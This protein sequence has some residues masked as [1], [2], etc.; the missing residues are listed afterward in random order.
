MKYAKN[1]ADFW[2]TIKLCFQEINL[3][4]IMFAVYGYSSNSAGLLNP[5]YIPLMN[6]IGLAEIK[7]TNEVLEIYVKDYCVRNFSLSSNDFCIIPQFISYIKYATA[8]HVGFIRHILQYTMD[9]LQYKIHRKE[10]I[11]K[12]IYK[13]LNSHSFYQS[14]NNCH[15]T[16]KFNELSRKQQEICESVYLNRSILFLA[17]CDN[18]YLVK[19]RIFVVNVINNMEHLCFTVPLIE[20]FFFHQQYYGS[21][22]SASSTS[23]SL[24]EFIV[25]TFTIICKEKSEILKYSLGYENNKMLLEQILQKEFYRIG[26]R[27]LG[28]QYFLSCNVG[29]HLESSGFI[30]FYIDGKEWVIELLREDSKMN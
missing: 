25:K 1:A 3:Y 7:F 11:W 28:N 17:Y 26:T 18:E 22:I 5:I 21:E 14:I 20:Q 16:P 23:D 13:Y 6:S 4:I 9:V 29:S 27:A 30:D 8:E 24:Y 10:L 19:Y 12:D 15:A 2:D